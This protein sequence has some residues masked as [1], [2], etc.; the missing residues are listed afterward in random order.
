MS[1]IIDIEYYSSSS[2]FR[3]LDFKFEKPKKDQRNI[4]L[5]KLTQ[6]VSFNLPISNIL[7][8][9]Q[10]DLGVN[11]LKFLFEPEEN[12]AFLEF[13]YQLDNLALTTSNTESVNWFGKKISPD[14]LEKLYLPPYQS[15]EVTELVDGEEVENP[16]DIENEVFYYVEVVVD[17]AKMLEK[18][19]EIDN[20]A[21]VQLLVKLEGM[22]FFKKTF[23]YLITLQG[24]MEIPS[25][26]SSQEDENVDLIDAIASQDESPKEVKNEIRT[27]SKVEPKSEPNRR[28][29]F[30]KDVIDDLANVSI[31]SKNMKSAVLPTVTKDT[32]SVVQ[33]TATKRTTMSRAEVES[34]LNIKREEAR[35]IFSNAERASRAAESLRT[36]ALGASKE[37]KELESLLNTLEN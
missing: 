7:E 16:E 33:S 32:T 17:D 10:D 6:P 31:M 34:K 15:Q 21:D 4:Y 2:S 14:L 29:I 25:E 9:Y 12:E 28:E 8:I 18:L 36:K 23:S 5:A 3:K 1:K 24:V 11:N 37:I 13:F 20:D 19:S 30:D 27:E 35:K 22:R 26:E